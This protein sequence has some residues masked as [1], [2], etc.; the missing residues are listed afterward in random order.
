MPLY[1]LKLSKADLD[2]LLSILDRFWTPWPTL[3]AP[4]RR[5]LVGI[6]DD[7]AWRRHLLRYICPHS[8]ASATS[9][10]DYE[11]TIPRDDERISKGT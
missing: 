7:N 10:E 1:I 2:L 6:Q 11:C 3:Y 4:S 8:D 9:A 5:E